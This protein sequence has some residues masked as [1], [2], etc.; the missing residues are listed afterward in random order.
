[1]RN[2]EKE[3]IAK[4]QISNL[5]T[6]DPYLNDFYYQIYSRDKNASL[7][8]D[9]ID[10]SKKTKSKQKK[11]LLITNQLVGQGNSAAVSDQMKKQMKRLVDQRKQ[12]PQREGSLSLEGALGKIIVTTSRNPKKA[13]GLTSF[14]PVQKTGN[15]TI[16]TKLSRAKL[17]KNIE[18]V[19]DCILNLE[20]LHRQVPNAKPESVY[21]DW[22]KE[23][24]IQKH[25]L[26]TNLHVM[27]NKVDFNSPHLFVTMLN[28]S[29]MLKAFPRFTAF[30]KADQILSIFSLIFNRFENLESI[31]V[32]LDLISEQVDLF[33]NLVLPPFVEILSEKSLDVIN[34]LT[35]IFIERH[36]FVWVCRSRVGLA[37]MTAFL[38][39]AEI[40]K[41]NQESSQ[42]E[43]D[44]AL[45]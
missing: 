45:W 41:S 8:E 17:M 37:I 24:N 14:A 10:P 2:F 19:Y 23:V 3:L 36:D 15:N 22:E 12:R 9:E 1:M 5:V 42:I 39:R 43:T 30:M 6:D 40:L 27:D 21:K 28:F 13:L 29:K 26:F 16:E 11:Q 20:K 18:I 44:V 25:R 34:G 33:M 31:T 4:I 35:R 32:P 38:S 7:S